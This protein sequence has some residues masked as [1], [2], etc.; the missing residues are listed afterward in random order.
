MGG[1]RSTGEAALVASL[2]VLLAVAIVYP[3][4]QVLSVAVVADGAPTLRP[5]LAF[6][7][8]P[9]FRE[10]LVN[11]LLA[12]VLAVVIGSVI[13][14]PLALLTVRYRF[15]GHGLISVLG[16]LPLVI[17]PFVGAVAFQ[18]I[19]GRSGAVNLFLLD[20]WGVTVPFMEGFAGVVLVQSLHYF[21]FI[22]LNTAAALG[23]LDRSLEEAAQ[24]LGAS[25]LRLF[26]R[27]LLP[28]ALPGYA[29]GAL[30]TFIRVI[31]DLG[32]PLMLNYTRLLAPQAYV[33][34][35]TVG[36]TDV[37]GYVICVILVALS[38]AALW[39]SKAALARG[40][41][42]ALGRGGETPPVVLGRR[43]ALGAWLLVLLL[44]GP[45]LLPHVGIVLLSFS[46]VW[47]LSPLPTVYTLGNYEEIL[48]RS[49]GFVVNT[50]RY[51]GLAALLDVALGAVIAWLLLRGRVRARH[52]LDTVSTVPLAIPGVVL[53]VGYLRAFGGLRVP[54]LGEPLTSTWLI[55]VVVYAV[56]RLPYAVR[57]A[58]AAL[59]QL[60]PALEE[61]AQSLGANRPRTF[62]RITLPLMTRGLLAGGLLAFI[63]SA[64][65]LSSTILLVPRVELGPLSYGIYLYMQSAVGRGPGAALGVVAIVLVAAG[66]WA[67]S[68]L[69]RRSRAW[70]ARP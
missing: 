53:A 66:T 65:D 43:G 40:E 36:L 60:S 2:L 39:L 31:D 37:D 55:L 67:A 42:A 68:G 6:F 52:W 25:G 5:L 64:V 35:T 63:T 22:L 11:T 24:N 1:H 38:V 45:A 27:V 7:A 44:L 10:A 4:I 15:P 18:Q 21:P 17:P 48:V 57:G 13:A 70:G 26:R 41:F 30:L 34:V 33:R 46:R 62:R 59:Q 8:R 56:R 32:T 47:S 20:R 3:L 49:P 12:G 51:A 28:L 61:A 23:G 14:V 69:A 9:L 58:Y 16:V 29:A 50:L 54:G 19:L